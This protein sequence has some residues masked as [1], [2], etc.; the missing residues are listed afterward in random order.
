MIVIAALVIGAVTGAARARR[1]QGNGFD[2][3]QYAAVHAILFGI[4][5]LFLTLLIDRLV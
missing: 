2:I 5:G 4:C 3:A 1:R